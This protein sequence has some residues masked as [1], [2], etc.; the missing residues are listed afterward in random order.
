VSEGNGQRELHFII[1]D[2]AEPGRPLAA[3]IAGGDDGNVFVADS[4]NWRVEISSRRMASSSRSSGVVTPAGSLARPAT[5]W[6]LS[7]PLVYLPPGAGNATVG[8]LGDTIV[9]GCPDDQ[10]TLVFDRAHELVGAWQENPFLTDVPPGFRRMAKS[11]PS[12][13][14]ARC[15]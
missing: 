3:A 13:T 15:P 11:S 10:S 1:P 6:M 8:S 7:R 12:A 4:A 9:Q 2:E 5:R 14:T